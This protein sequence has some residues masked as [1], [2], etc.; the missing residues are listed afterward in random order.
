MTVRS[1][2]AFIWAKAGVKSE[3][4]REG[5]Y[6]RRNDVRPCFFTSAWKGDAHAL[7]VGPFAFP[8]NMLPARIPA[9]PIRQE[10]K[11]ESSLTTDGRRG[12]VRP[13]IDFSPL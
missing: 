13:S 1:M 4:R 8:R 9:D 11:S 12:L 3:Q 5:A 7:P 10:K 6:L 2:H